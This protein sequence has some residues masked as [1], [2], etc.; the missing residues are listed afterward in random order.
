MSRDSAESHAN[1]RKELGLQFTLLADTDEKLC[2]A[3]GTL[4]ERESDGK[5]YMGVQRSTFLIDPAG[6]VRKVWPKVD[7]AGHVA[8]VLSSL[9]ALTA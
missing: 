7:V 9:V 6:V 8:D 3:F 4:V 1:F 5:K 2:N